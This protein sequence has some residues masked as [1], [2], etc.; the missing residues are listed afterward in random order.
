[1]QRTARPTS[2][3]GWSGAR[4]STGTVPNGVDGAQEVSAFLAGATREP[5]A[6]VIDGESGIGKTTAWAAVAERARQAGFR[7]LSARASE[8]EGDVAFGV[9]SVLA[10]DLES[11]LVTSLPDVQRRAV[12]RHLLH[13][14]RHQFDDDQ[15]AVVAAFTAIVNRLSDAGPVL[16]A[17]DDVQW[18]DTASRDLLAFAARRLRGRVGLLLTERTGPDGATAWLKLDR[19][20]A[21]SRLT[22]GP[23]DVRSLQRMIAERFGRPFPRR[24]MARIA[25]VSGGNPSYAVELAQVMGPTIST[26]A[27]PP[28]IVEALEDAIGHFDDDVERALLAA[29]CVDDPTVDV[30]AAITSTP[31]ER[32]VH[33]LEEP[34]TDGIIAIEGNRVRF[35]PPVLAHGVYGRARPSTR[36][37]LHRAIADME[38]LPAQ[39]ARHMALAAVTADPATLAALDA[40]VAD[41]SVQYDPAAAAE[42]LELAIGLGGDTVE[43]RLAAA[44]Q[45]LR[46]G[47]VDRCRELA[48]SVIADPSGGDQRAH[49]R[50]LV[51]RTLMARGEFRDATDVLQLATSDAVRRPESL[52]CVHLVSAVAHSS[53]GDGDG[54]Q[55]HSVQAMTYAERL[56]DPHAISRALAVHVSLQCR[57]GFGLD[58][59]T[60]NRAMD[61]EDLEVTTCVRLSAHAVNAV[62]LVWMGRLEEA[63]IALAAVMDRL[64][65]RGEDADLSWIE[66]HSAMAKVGLGRYAEAARVAESLAVRAEQVGGTH[67]HM[68]AAVSASLAAAYAGREHDARIEAEAALGDASASDGQWA[69]PWPIIALGFLEVSLGNHA[70]ALDVLRPLIFRWQQAAAVDMTTFQSVPDAVEA[71]IAV[72][73]LADAE[74]LV[75]LLRDSA[76]RL[77]HRWMAATAARC[78]GMLMAARGEL[79]DAERAVASAM[80]EHALVPSPFERARTQLVLGQVQRRLRHGTVARATLDE[81]RATFERLGTPLWTA[82]AEAELAHIGRSSRAQDTRL[83]SA[84]WRVAELAA[85]GMSNKEVASALFISAKTVEGNLGRVYRKLGI[86]NRVEL[87]HRLAADTWARPA[88]GED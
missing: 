63:E 23:M 82:R 33:L 78:Q 34:E 6:L 65:A 73:A 87:R 4:R 84:E 36:R 75:V 51:A 16:I 28:S 49:A 79:G 47:D 80:A 55:R 10:G 66:F 54:A 76:A 2:D 26:T 52:M 22:I 70:Q 9:A 24:T 46:A 13:L 37:A 59:S 81:A 40:A 85:A 83:T 44:R 68:M 3:P 29:A 32:L 43:R 20:G 48:E 60:L 27:L 72:K 42:L 31:V 77:D 8:R 5:A 17:V 38:S 64:A 14:D 45:H 41:E 88:R 67:V 35:T 69:T 25:K 1:M 86:R 7:V 58:Q 62:I 12:E 57:R 53:L 56:E 19:P 30:M 18:I 61:L 11:E 39:R 71:M 50:L 21:L 74:R 15:R